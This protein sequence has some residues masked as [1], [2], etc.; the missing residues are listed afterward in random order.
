MKE[1]TIK[2]RLYD[3]DNKSQGKVE[4]KKGKSRN[5]ENLKKEDN[6][7]NSYIPPDFSIYIYIWMSS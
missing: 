7:R 2:S 1:A 4:I 3:G 5:Q 6:F